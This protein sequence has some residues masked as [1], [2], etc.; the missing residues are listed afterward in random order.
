M[1][2]EGVIAARR[3]EALHAEA[4]AERAACVAAMTKV[5]DRMADLSGDDHLVRVVCQRIDAAIGGI[6]QGLHLKSGMED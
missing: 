3:G 5:R 2:G 6:E 1:S 4:A